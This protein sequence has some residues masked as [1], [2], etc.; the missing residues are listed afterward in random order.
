M[1]KIV[2]GVGGLVLS[3]FLLL[4]FM[5]MILPQAQTVISDANITDYTGLSTAVAASPVIIFLAGMGASIWAIWKGNGE[6]RAFAGG[7]KHSKR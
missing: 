3:T 6:R 1:M 4:M 5:T 2:A 7:G